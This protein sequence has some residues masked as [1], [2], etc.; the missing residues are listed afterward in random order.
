MMWWRSK[1]EKDMAKMF[2][3]DPNRSKILSGLRSLNRI[4]KRWPS[5]N[6]IHAGS[7]KRARAFRAQ[8]TEL[9]ECIPSDTGPLKK[10]LSTVGLEMWHLTHETSLLKELV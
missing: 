9:R 7:I 2:S 8:L 4:A 5:R 10:M 6:K 3:G 1:L